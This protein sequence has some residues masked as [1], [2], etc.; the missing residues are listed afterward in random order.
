VIRHV[1]QLHWPAA[2]RASW[3]VLRARDCSAPFP[4]NDPFAAQVAMERFCRVVKDQRGD[5]FD[6]AGTVRLEVEWCV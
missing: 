6:L 3:F 4:D 5:S 1:F 2:V